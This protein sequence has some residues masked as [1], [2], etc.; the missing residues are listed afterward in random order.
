VACGDD[1]A[2]LSIIFKDRLKAEITPSAGNVDVGDNSCNLSAVMSGSKSQN[3]SQN[4]RGGE[5]TAVMGGIE[6][7]LRNASIDGSATINVFAVWG[8]IEIKVPG[9][10]TVISQGVPI[11]G[12][13]EDRT[14]PP[15]D[16]SKTLFIQGY[17]IMG[18]VEIR[19]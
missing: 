8:G 11:L 10:W 12:G 7:D 19:N 16:R 1:F 2:G 4:F 6:L 17:A 13:I 3:S 9:D 14:V 18:G 5:L 15:M